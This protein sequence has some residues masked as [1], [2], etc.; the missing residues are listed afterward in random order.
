M[1]GS[2]MKLFR[3]TKGITETFLQMIWN[4][5]LTVMD[6]LATWAIGILCF[7]VFYVLLFLVLLMGE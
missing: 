2:E 3:D 6:N 4:R 1:G 5:R 7:T